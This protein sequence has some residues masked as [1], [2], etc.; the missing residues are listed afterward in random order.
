[1]S[2]QTDL[3]II[4]PATT[5]GSW[6]FFDGLLKKLDPSIAVSIC[7][8]QKLKMNYEKMRFFYFPMPRYDRHG[9]LINSELLFMV[10]YSIPMLL[11]SS[12]VAL[13]EKP[14]LIVS[15]GFAGCY[16]ILPIAKLTNSKLIISHHGYFSGY[17]PKIAGKFLEIFQSPIDL[18][19]VNSTT[20][21]KDVGAII[22]QKKILIVEHWADPKFFLERNRKQ[23]RL[24]LGLDKKFV[25]VF[26]GRID[27]E[28]HVH[29]IIE[30]AEKNILN[31][32]F[33]FIFIGRGELENMVQKAIKVHPNISYVGYLSDQEK[34][35][36]FLT[37][38]DVV[39]SYADEDYLARPAVEALACGT[40]VVISEKPAI[41]RKAEKKVTVSSEL[42]RGIG[43]LIDTSNPTK[44]AN[45]LLN[46]KNSGILTDAFRTYCRSYAKERYSIQ[47][48]DLFVRF[49]HK[50]LGKD[51]ACR[52]N[53]LSIKMKNKVE[54]I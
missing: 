31:E 12:I 19:A 4:T 14:R 5:G 54:N 39:W 13:I 2:R 50:L 45:F 47:N 7:S 46:L 26:A 42:V 21:E 3:L 29:F 32:D 23:L 27:R 1:M 38:A 20:S 17:L 6:I 24:K 48:L 40:P 8:A 34:L 9:L 33:A 37:V 51:F 30:T 18:V 11:F 10:A 15:N 41:M 22:E 35:A 16:G 49:V 36:E 25:V 53:E 52:V 43:W 44:A 28:K